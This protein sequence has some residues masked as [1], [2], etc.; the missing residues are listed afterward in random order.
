MTYRAVSAIIFAGIVLLQLIVFMTLD[1]PT[2]QVANPGYDPDRRNTTLFGN[3]PTTTGV[4]A[5]ALQGQQVKYG[6]IIAGTILIGGVVTFSL[7]NKE[8][9]KQE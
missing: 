1:T 4:D 9:G 5:A 7:P 6:I 8:I 3:S 2:T